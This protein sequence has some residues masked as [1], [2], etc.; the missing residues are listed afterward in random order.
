MFCAAAML[1]GSD[2][3]ID[4]LI[5]VVTVCSIIHYS[6]TILSGARRP[7]LLRVFNSRGAVTFGAFS[8]SLYLMHFPSLLKVYP[9]MQTLSPVSEFIFRVV[10]CIPWILV[11]S[12]Y[13]HCV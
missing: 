1:G 9:L 11:V 12:Y 8:Y 3:L 13:F 5:G 2:L 6:Q 7:A 4:P 10:V